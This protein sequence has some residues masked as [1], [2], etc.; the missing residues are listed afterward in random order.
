MQ[1]VPGVEDKAADPAGVL[2]AGREV[3]GLQV[4]L[5]VVLQPEALATDQATKVFR[6]RV[7]NL[8]IILENHS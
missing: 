1:A 4:V 5:Q 6:K 8:Y 2:V 3:L 7:E